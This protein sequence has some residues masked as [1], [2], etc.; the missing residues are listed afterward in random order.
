[1]CWPRVP[2]S[3]SEI[4]II[5]FLLA[6]QKNFNYTGNATQIC[7]SITLFYEQTTKQH[8][9]SESSQSRLQIKGLQALSMQIWTL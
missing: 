8:K 6:F 5:Y 4:L 2:P 7:N 3:H 1:M 9:Q